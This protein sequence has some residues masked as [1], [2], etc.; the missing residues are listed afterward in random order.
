[1]Q[2]KQQEIS[3]D[4]F[5]N[6]AHL[7][8]I[9]IIS[10]LIDH[11]GAALLGFMNASTIANMDITTLYTICRQIGR[12]AFPIFAFII[13]QGYQH[14]SKLNVYVRNLVLFALISQPFFTYTF[15]D[16]LNYVGHLNIF[17]TLAMGITALALFEKMEE[18]NQPLLQ[19]LI[20]LVVAWFAEWINV[21]Y[22]FY[23][24]V[25]IMGLGILRHQRWG[26]MFFGFLMGL[27]Q[28]P[29]ASLAFVPIYFYN[30]K[31][32]KQNKWFFYLFY[33]GHL[34]VLFLI[35]RYFL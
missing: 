31:R 34:L 10:M 21:D 1:M 33:P 11:I 35:R 29:A 15:Y 28:S 18:R 24:I 26:Q 5:L 25:L 32:G 12:L 6:G 30:G 20:V 19:I 22:G 13:I 27:V 14:T 23:G 7:K 9:A 2:V 4:G 16:R 17:W 8:W 3:N